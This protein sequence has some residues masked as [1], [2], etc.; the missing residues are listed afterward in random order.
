MGVSFIRYGRLRNEMEVPALYRAA[1]VNEWTYS[2]ILLILM[3]A[4]GSIAIVKAFTESFIGIRGR[5]YEKHISIAMR[6]GARDIEGKG[7]SGWQFFRRVDGWGS[8][9]DFSFGRNFGR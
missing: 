8:C 2:Q 1:D 9:N 3:L 7:V 6:K 5:R 4:G